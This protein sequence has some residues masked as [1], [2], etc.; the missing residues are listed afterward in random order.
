MEPRRLLAV[1]SVS[2]NDLLLTEGISSPSSAVATFTVYR[3]PDPDTGDPAP[4]PNPQDFTTTIEWGDGSASRGTVVADGVDSFAVY[5]SHVYKDEGEYP[6]SVSATDL[7]DDGGDSGSGTAVVTDADLTPKTPPTLNVIEGTS[8]SLVFAQWDDANPSA[9]GSDFAGS[10]IDLGDGSAPISGRVQRDPSG[11]F[12]LNATVDYGRGGLYHASV[13]VVDVGGAEFWAPVNVLVA[14]APLSA[15]PYTPPHAVEGSPYIETIAKFTD[16]NSG[17]LPSDFDPTIDWGDGTTADPS[18][19]IAK[20]SGGT[21]EVSGNHVYRDAG[22]YTAKVSIQDT[23]VDST[24]AGSTLTL[25]ATVTVDDA[26]L[27]FRGTNATAV[28][29]QAFNGLLGELSDPNQND[30]PNE[31][32]TSISFGD[33]THSILT[34]QSKGIGLFDYDVSHTWT[35]PG[36]YTVQFDVKDDGGATVT[37]YSTVVVSAPSPATIAP[38][39]L[40]FNVAQGGVDLAY[41]IDGADLPTSTDVALIWAPDN[42]YDSSRD[43]VAFRVT[44]ATAQGPHTLHVDPLALT[45][46]PTGT[47]DLLLLTDT[48]GH[49]GPTHAPIARPYQAVETVTPRYNGSTNPDVVGRFFA[50]PNAVNEAFTIVVS[51]PLAALRPGVFARVGGVTFQGK[52][53]G[54]GKTFVIDGIDPGVLPGGNLPLAIVSSSA[55]TATKLAEQDL[56]LSVVALPDWIKGMTGLKSSFTPT[57]NGLDGLY[58]F[59]GGVA[60]LTPRTS[61]TTPADLP[62]SAFANKKIAVDIAFTET[63]SA[64]LDRDH[65]PVATPSLTGSVTVLGWV[66]SKNLTGPVHTGDTSFGMT[67]DSPLDRDT[68]MPTGGLG[69]TFTF[70]TTATA[71]DLP[72]FTGT[73]IGSLGAIPFVYSV[74][75]DAKLDLS[76]AAGLRVVVSPGTGLS[77]VPEST[78]IDLTD[79]LLLTGRAEAGWFV[80]TRTGDPLLDAVITA[81]RKRS[82]I[83]PVASVYATIGGELDLDL[84]LGYKGSTAPGPDW[85]SAGLTLD[86]TLEGGILLGLSPT[87]AFTLK[88]DVLGF[89]FPKDKKP[90]PYKKDLLGP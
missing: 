56:T 79:K 82:P 61:L 66:Y 44:S 17:A 10:Q 38:T 41:L 19:L 51:D 48:Q 33:G 57:G 81:F 20:A 83:D 50:V 52:P 42:S 27:T 18:V 49:F 31:Y 40:A 65:D 32:T 55:S 12:D 80:P 46:P 35:K 26:P 71:I 11:G 21:F 22:N 59:S 54:D 30:Q 86:A 25:G 5:S 23:A 4:D 29:G 43:T 24:V 69:A 75:A 34:P 89:F 37:G 15:E 36:T 76:V 72:L 16:V 1:T 45:D 68:L 70:T 87:S 53:A 6:I 63:V 88:W 64:P 67:L 3:E 84:R 60:D 39:S 9:Q 13:H 78:F 2:V 28:A 77:I 90:F 14:D 62:L 8:T 73:G 85:V 7:Y 74:T 58:N 47:N